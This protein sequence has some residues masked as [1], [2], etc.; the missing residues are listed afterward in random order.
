[1]QHDSHEFLMHVLG[2]LQD[3]E[4]PINKKNFNGD[5]TPENKHRTMD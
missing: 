5:V 2:S 4:K 1:M 3:E